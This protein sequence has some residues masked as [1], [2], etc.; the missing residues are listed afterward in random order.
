MLKGKFTFFDIYM[1]YSSPIL[2]TNILKLLRIPSPLAGFLHAASCLIA[3]RT[4]G[5]IGTRSD[6]LKALLI[7]S[8]ISKFHKTYG[9]TKAR[10]RNNNEIKIFSEIFYSWLKMKQLF[11]SDQV[12]G[13]IGQLAA[14]T[15]PVRGLGILSNFRILVL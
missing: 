11:R 7:L 1:F 5:P 15:S 6:F 9:G 13:A 10:W 12:R 14:C 2:G 4:S 3:S 8:V